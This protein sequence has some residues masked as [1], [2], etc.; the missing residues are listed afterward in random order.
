MLTKQRTG[1]TRSLKRQSYI[2]LLAVRGKFDSVRWIDGL[3]LILWI[4]YLFKKKDIS[5]EPLP[6]FL[7]TQKRRI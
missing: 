2:Y 1:N 7:Y 6:I 3:M 4:K 5:Y